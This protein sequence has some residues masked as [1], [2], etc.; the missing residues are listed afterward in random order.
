MTR[1]ETA[2]GGNPASRRLRCQH[3]LRR[4]PACLLGGRVEPRVPAGRV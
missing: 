2:G 3:P 4:A 1:M